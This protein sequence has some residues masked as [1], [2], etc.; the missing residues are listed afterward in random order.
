MLGDLIAVA[1]LVGGYGL[2]AG[3]GAR[4][5]LRDELT[6]RRVRRGAPH[7]GAVLDV[8]RGFDHRG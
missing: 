7:D 2:I 1:L 8:T 6:R 5:V 3:L 4:A